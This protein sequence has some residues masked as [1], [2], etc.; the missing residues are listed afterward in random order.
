M[1]ADMSTHRTGGASIA[2]GG[3]RRRGS[4]AGV[5][6]LW[7]ARRGSLASEMRLIKV[8]L[9]WPGVLTVPCILGARQ[10]L[11]PGANGCGEPTIS[12]VPTPKR[13]SACRRKGGSGSLFT[14][15]SS[16]RWSAVRSMSLQVSI[17]VSRPL[18]MAA[19][20]CQHH[21]KCSQAKTTTQTP[22]LSLDA[23]GGVGGGAV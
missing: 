7:L 11:A 19:T 16:E 5:H 10:Q 9:V 1:S 20:P 22:A 17:A 12:S 15:S 21:A 18:D 3:L 4:S 23:G 8:V 14:S 13:D 2:V 6:V